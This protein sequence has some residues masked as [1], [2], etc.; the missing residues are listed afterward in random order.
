[1]KQSNKQS[2]LDAAKQAVLAVGWQ[3]ATAADIAR[4]AGVSRMTLYRHWPDVGTLL[5]DLTVREWSVTYLPTGEDVTPSSIAE[6]VMTGAHGITRDE[7]YLATVN[8]DPEI[9]LPYLINRQGRNWRI[10]H[11][12]LVEVITSGQRAGRVRDGDATV[13]AASIQAIAESYSLHVAGAASSPDEEESDAE[14]PEGPD[15][16]PNVWS[17]AARAEFTTMIERYLTP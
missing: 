9:L 13:M 17:G 11:A 8:N 3:R 7:L 10:A 6:G 2:I 16:P 12:K 14:S 1:M 15:L 4:R 5:R